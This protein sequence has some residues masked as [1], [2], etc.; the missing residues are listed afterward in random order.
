MEIE[1]ELNL[2]TIK[3][4]KVMLTESRKQSLKNLVYDLNALYTEIDVEELNNIETEIR[5]NL[6]NILEW[7]DKW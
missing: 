1:R 4:K 6:I 5:S 7:I 3:I 2:G